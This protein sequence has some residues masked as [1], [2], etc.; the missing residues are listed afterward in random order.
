VLN[1]TGCEYG[2][3]VDWCQTYWELN[4]SDPEL[5]SQCCSTCMSKS[6]TTRKPTTAS[7]RTIRKILKLSP[8]VTRSA[9]TRRTRLTKIRIST[10]T[11]A[12]TYKVNA[13]TRRTALTIL[14]LSTITMAPTFKI[15]AVTKRNTLKKVLVST[16]TPTVKLTTL[17]RGALQTKVT[18]FTTGLFTT[19]P[20]STTDT[21]MKLISYSAT[22]S[23]RKTK[24]VE[25]STR[26]ETTTVVP[27]VPNR[28]CPLGDGALFC[29]TL[30]VEE[31]YNYEHLCCETCPKYFRNTPG[32]EFIKWE[33][34]V[35]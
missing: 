32:K 28:S 5:A 29:S 1:V 30:L 13:V 27:V 6:L 31:C 12:P 24:S 10:I 17:K 35:I 25:S 15:N 22:L 18:S 7:A 8:T 26:L 23:T 4:C 16:R 3:H 2:D 33:T 9:L 34:Q 19:A 20:A 21:M 11:V 14:P